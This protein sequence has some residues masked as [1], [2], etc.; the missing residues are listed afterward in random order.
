MLEDIGFYTLSDQR[1]RSAS[2]T[3]RLMRCELILSAR[4]NFRCPYCRRVGGPDMPYADAESVVDGWI[5]EGLYA[6]RFSGGEPTL[7]KRLPELVARA[8]TGGIERIAVSTNG[9]APWA[10][11]LRLIEAGVDD[12]SVSLDACCAADGDRMAGG[13]R[14]SWERVIDNI[15]ALSART[16][17]T[18]G[19]VVTDENA[20]TVAETVTLADSL[21]V[22]DIRLIPAAQN[23]DHLSGVEIPADVLARHPILRYRVANL[24]S[25]TSVRGLSEADANRCRLAL[26]DMAV[27][28]GRHYPCII[29]LR[30]GGE[31]IGPVGADMRADRA[32]W[33]ETHD[34]RTDPICS[35]NCLDVCRAYNNAGR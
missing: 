13:V 35:A 22:A 19:I 32:Q 4:C 25:G 21:G 17:V 2:A 34:T 5:A 31:A 6:I 16:Y 29:Y 10:T 23:G 27:C 3:S 28:E 30:E 1:A 14:G 24:R 7:Y 18:V 12:F 20:A 33:S 11:Y 8:R 26:D 15:R 9:S